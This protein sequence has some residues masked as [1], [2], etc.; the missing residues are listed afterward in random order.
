MDRKY[1]ITRQNNS[2]HQYPQ[3]ELTVEET[4]HL[5]YDLLI[6]LYEASTKIS[7]YYDYGVICDP[8]QR[9][10]LF[11]ALLPPVYSPLP[12]LMETKLAPYTPL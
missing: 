2:T 11:A 3:I 5:R 7:L 4:Y 10:P 1:E 8:I 9:D 12:Y 6:A